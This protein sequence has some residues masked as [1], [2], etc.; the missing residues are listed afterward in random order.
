MGKISATD[1]WNAE[2]AAKKDPTKQPHYLEV[3]KRFR[4]QRTAK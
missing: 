1:V 4:E 2:Q 3:V